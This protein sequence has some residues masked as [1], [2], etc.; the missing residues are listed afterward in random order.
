MIIL[1]AIDLKDGRCVRL[2]KGEFDTVHTVAADALETAALFRAEGAEWL[3][4]VDLDGALSGKSANREIIEKVVKNSGLKLEVGGGVRKMS[5][6]DRL[7]N[8]GVAR[9]VIGSAAVRNPG[10]VEEAAGKYGERIAIGIDALGGEVRV[11]GWT[12]GSGLNYLDFA[13]QMEKLGVKY[14]I[15]TDID[16]DG[17]LTGPAIPA[18]RELMAAVRCKIIASGGVGSNADIEALR[19]I[20][21]Y[22]AIVGKAIYTCD[23]D[24]KKAIEE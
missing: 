8:L 17:M 4:M 19:E 13:K 1:P 12:E 22:G 9:A 10:F 6:L 5:D 7:M 20:G 2:Q 23:V 11:S 24:L 3:H 21:V 18:L 16:R 15:F 14:I